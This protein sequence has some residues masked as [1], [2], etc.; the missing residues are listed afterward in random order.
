[1]II[2][3]DQFIPYEKIQRVNSIEDIASTISNSTLVF[4]FEKNIMQYCMQNDINYGVEVLNIKE[5]IYANS[6]KAKYIFCTDDI[7]QEVQK[8]AENYLFDSKIIATIS[9]ENEIEDI[10]LNGIDG[11]VF[12]AIL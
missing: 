3:G 11:V 4:K 1:M 8:I 6:M 9:S 5:S 12:K 7:I 10:A 2:I